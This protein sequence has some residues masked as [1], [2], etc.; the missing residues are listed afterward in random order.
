MIFKLAIAAGVSTGFFHW[1][2]YLG[3]QL[4]AWQ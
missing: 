4:G 1:L 2:N 3:Q